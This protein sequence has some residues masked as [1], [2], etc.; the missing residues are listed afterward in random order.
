MQCEKCGAS[1]E[2]DESYEYAGQTLCEDCYLDIKAAPKV[3]DPW[4]VYTA[5]KEVAKNLTL[6][7][8]QERII[9]L[10]K[11]KGPL[12]KEQICRELNI[13]EQEFEINFAALRHMELARGMKKDNKV[14]FAAFT[15]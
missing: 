5:K 8:L 14:Y 3:C 11:E 13:P 7:P 9:T 2:P 12:T 1:I 10:M 6:T 15:E 4:A